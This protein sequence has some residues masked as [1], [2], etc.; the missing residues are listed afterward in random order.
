MYININLYYIFI[1]YIIY[2]KNAGIVQAQEITNK[3]FPERSPTLSFTNFCCIDPSS[4]QGKGTN[5]SEDSSK[6]NDLARSGTGNIF[7]PWKLTCSS[8]ILKCWGHLRQ[9][10]VQKNYQNDVTFSCKKKLH[11]LASN[12][13]CSILMRVLEHLW[14]DHCNVPSLSLA[15]CLRRYASLFGAKKMNFKLVKTKLAWTTHRLHAEP[16]LKK[17]NLLHLQLQK[18]AIFTVGD[19]KFVHGSGPFLLLSLT[20]KRIWEQEPTSKA[21]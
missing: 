17:N 6:Q 7:L 15:S 14:D 13:R 11:H 21:Q 10:D 12:P 20:T 2:F 16:C 4:W 5:R 3:K 9:W 19:T 18:T 1:I 8:K